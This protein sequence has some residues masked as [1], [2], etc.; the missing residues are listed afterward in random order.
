[1]KILITGGFGFLGGRIAQY[2]ADSGHYI[3]LGTRKACAPPPWLL[4]SSVVSIDW[5]DING[6]ISACRSHDVVIHAAGINAQDCLN[7]PKSALEF[8]GGAT[9]RLVCCAKIAGVK[10]FIYLST[11]HVYSSPLQ[12]EIDENTKPQNSHPYA[13]SHLLG[14]KYVLNENKMNGVVLRLSNVFGQPVDWNVNCWSLLVN[15]LCKQAVEKGMLALHSSGLQERDFIPMSRICEEIKGLID[16]F[17]RLIENT[18]VKII[19]MGSGRSQTVIAMTNLIQER[20]IK[21][22][23]YRPDIIFKSGN[24]NDVPTKLVYKSIYPLSCNRVVEDYEDRKILEI[25]QLLNYCLNKFQ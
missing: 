5:N 11:A 9:E 6:M 18:E 24:L 19:N 13:T 7:D 10:N 23:G 3:S 14:E 22:L 12:G 20:C 16:G 4:R 25:D 1:M 2:L 15:D 17:D 8:N 21:V